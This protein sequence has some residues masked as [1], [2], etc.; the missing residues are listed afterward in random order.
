M[1]T[2]SNFSPTGAVSQA[3][4]SRTYDMDGRMIDAATRRAALAD[5]ARREWLLGML[6]LAAAACR[7][8]R[9]Q[10]GESTLTVFYSLESGGGSSENIA[11]DG[12]AQWLLFEPLAKQNVKGEFELRLA[13][14]WEH[15]ADYRTWTIRLR[16]DVK[17]QDGVPVT[18]H[19]IK[20]TL[21]L[22]S[23][24]DV[25]EAPPGFPPGSVVTVVDDSTFTIT[26]RRHIR[27]P[28]NETPFY[29]KH[30]L[31]H[32]DPKAFRSWDFWTHPVGNGPYRFVRQVPMTMTEYEASPTY[33]R[34]R[35]R[36]RRVV[37]KGLTAE[38]ALTELLSGHV[39]A[40]PYTM[41]MDLLK[42]RGDARFRAYHS[43][44]ST[45]MRAIV[46]HHGHP[47]FRDASV[48]RALTLAINRHELRQILN[49]PEQI[50]ILDVAATEA[51]FR[52]GELPNAL[53]YDPAQ[54]K[55]LLEEAG[56]RDL[57][58]GRI[59]E[60]DGKPLRFV[61][62]AEQSDAAS[63]V[64]VQTQ[65]RA[66]GIHMDVQFM[67]RLVVRAR[68]KSGT[69]AA[70]ILEVNT[71]PDGMEEWFGEGSPFGYANPRVMALVRD[72][73]STVDPDEIDRIYR[74]LMPIF[75]ADVPVTFLFPRAEV[76]VALRDLQGLSSPYG[77]DMV[78]HMEDLWLDDGSQQ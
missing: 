53:A 52:R 48:R 68:A 59:R 28:I 35:P 18:A 8:E 63:P 55:Q 32:L 70:L 24:P 16:T 61:A 45:R 56:W 77:A 29:P 6:A 66:V 4:F 34:G 41:P 69:F 15:S 49:L 76:T 73:Q 13:R 20:F 64:Y 37:L 71:K 57:G 78:Y 22:L 38:S 67:D 25:L 39:D 62:L 44:R 23:H 42:I 51:Q 1:R 2:T 74:D 10:S 58:S 31:G 60:R 14:S 11:L 50:P 65:L 43:I 72:A 21:D 17:W 7:R 30:L 54:A 19:D 27:N 12:S 33:Y 9:V 5:I 36:V 26:Y 46:W 3:T 75:Q 40:L 47:L